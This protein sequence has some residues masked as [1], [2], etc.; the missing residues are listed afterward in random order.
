MQSITL[1]STNNKNVKML[2]SY[3]Y[4]NAFEKVMTPK[5]IIIRL[6]DHNMFTS[7]HFILPW[8]KTIKV[9]FIA[10]SGIL[11]SPHSERNQERHMTASAIIV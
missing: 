1:H 2:I 9:N 5:C 3:L 8:Q 6:V 7:T 11:S 10:K 4:F